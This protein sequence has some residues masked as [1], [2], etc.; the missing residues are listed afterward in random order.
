M[1]GLKQVE[2]EMSVRGMRETHYPI[3]F[4]RRH[5]TLDWEFVCINNV[6]KIEYH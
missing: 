2:R 1:I 5:S 3:E 6:T 4:D